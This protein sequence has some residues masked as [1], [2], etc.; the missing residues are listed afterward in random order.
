MRYLVLRVIALFFVFSLAACGGKEAVRPPSWVEN[1]GN[2]AVGSSTTHV[3]G[4]HYQEELAIARA[5]ERLAARYGVEV[6]SVHTIKERV[7]NESVYLRSDKEISQVVKK[8]TVKAHV[9]EIWL[10]P[11]DKELWVWVYPV[12]D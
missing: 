12:S 7:V 11:A 10:N 6:E 5:R 3:R 9:R 8:T 4:R 2:G 1:P